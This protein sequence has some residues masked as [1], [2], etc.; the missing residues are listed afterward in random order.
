M[1]NTWIGNT[2][3]KIDT[4][5]RSVAFERKISAPYWTA[6]RFAFGARS[7][8]LLDGP[9]GV[10]GPASMTQFTIYR[11]TSRTRRVPTLLLR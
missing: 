7:V 4:K 6:R 1:A 5:R 8:C 2:T 10:A 9:S 3:G 11:V